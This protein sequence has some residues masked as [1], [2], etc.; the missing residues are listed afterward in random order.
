[1]PSL[2]FQRPYRDGHP[3][4]ASDLDEMVQWPLDALRS[5]L[6]A[7]VGK[8]AGA[9][10]ILHAEPLD[11]DGG[12]S[13]RC[14]DGRLE[15]S[16]STVLLPTGLV[17]VIP[18]S[19]A[20]GVGRAAVDPDSLSIVAPSSHALPWSPEKDRHHWPVA[21]LGST[22]ELRRALADF[23]QACRAALTGLAPANAGHGP[24]LAA[25]LQ[26][27]P[28]TPASSAM[29]ILAGLGHGVCCKVNVPAE[30]WPAHDTLMMTLGELARKLPSLEASGAVELRFKSS[31]QF[32]GWS[33]RSYSKL[34]GPRLE[35]TGAKGVE[36]DLVWRVAPIIDG[37]P[38][39][40]KQSR[41]IEKDWTG[42]V[43]GFPAGI[44]PDTPLNFLELDRRE[45]LGPI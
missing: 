18:A 34:S 3:L 26:L 21:F 39:Q 30:G 28:A 15:W 11:R 7:A 37:S 20:E 1:M 31:E 16:R 35:V 33:Q 6:G 9:W 42:F 22:P 14:R 41:V 40:W 27:A 45:E 24:W 10:G 32:G 4:K 44:S 43:V 25:A 5:L 12:E 38:W 36:A 13:I 8:G 19:Q 23:I 2:N 17:A 29:A